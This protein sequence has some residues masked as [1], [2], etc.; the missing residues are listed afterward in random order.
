MLQSLQLAFLF[1][2]L[3]RAL[4]VAQV[5]LVLQS[6]QLALLFPFLYRALI[7]AQVLIILL[8]IPAPL[9]HQIICTHSKHSLRRLLQIFVF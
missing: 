9:S 8:P 7:V 4:I 3:Y 2:F 5:L 6:L 1:P